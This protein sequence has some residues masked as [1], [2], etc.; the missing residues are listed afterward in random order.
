LV[1]TFPF[2]R[3]AAPGHRVTLAG[4]I[5][6][7]LAGWP[8][9]NAGCVLCETLL[10]GRAGFTENKP[11]PFY[12]PIVLVFASTSTLCAHLRSPPPSLVAGSS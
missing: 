5:K 10:S 1:P 4:K 12:V 8:D 9:G 6:Q 7:Q 2:I 3:H 11:D